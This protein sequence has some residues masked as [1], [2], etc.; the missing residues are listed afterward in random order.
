MANQNI[1]IFELK[2]VL[3]ANPDSPL[4]F[5]FE[6]QAI[7]P[8]Y[9]VT[10]VK[11]AAMNSLDCGSGKDQWE[12]IIVQLIDGSA[13]FKGKHMSCRKFMGIVGKAIESLSFDENTATFIEFAPN[14]E[15]L[16]KLVID[17]VDQNE[18][19]VLVHLSSPTA[20]CKPYQR[21]MA[22]KLVEPSNNSCCDSAM[23]V[24]PTTTC[25]DSSGAT[26]SAVISN[27]T[28]A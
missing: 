11:H 24:K 6:G 18:G 28:A 26:K 12:E 19:Q 22:G 21:A 23:S 25:C 2:A 27:G 20:L 9:H 1:N 13:L 15:G 4:I 14:N 16:R 7:N 10:E 5:S 3:E 17:R 8:S